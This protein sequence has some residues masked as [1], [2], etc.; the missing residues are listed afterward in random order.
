MI[1]GLVRGPRVRGLVPRCSVQAT[2]LVTAV[3]AGPAEASS[4]PP[5]NGDVNELEHG[6]R[7]WA[8]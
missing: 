4:P 8:E 5:N 1:R 6:F 7:E 3:G 2:D